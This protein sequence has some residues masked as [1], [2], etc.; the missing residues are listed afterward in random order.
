ML[1]DLSFCQGK[2]VFSD[3][4]EYDIGKEWGYCDVKNNRMF[5]VEL[6][7]GLK[8][9]GRCLVSN[10]IPPRVI[11]HGMYDSGDGFY[12]PAKRVLYTYDMRFL[13]TADDEEHSW[14]VS[15]CRKAEPEEP[16]DSKKN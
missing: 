11:P 12:D 16:N 10:M 14:I 4:L 13:R 3:E 6:Q 8:P 9:A 5:A 2:Y 7:N 15:K 1:C